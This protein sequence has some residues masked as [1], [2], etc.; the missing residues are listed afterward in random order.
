MPYRLKNR[1]MQIPGGF[2]FLQPETGWQP[3]RFSSFQTIVQAIIS[4]RSANPH[5]A[6]KHNWRMDVAGVE[7]E[8]DTFNATVCAR[9]GWTNYITVPEG[10]PPPPKLKAPSPEEQSQIAAA[11]GRVKKIWSG[12]RT[13]SDWVSQGGEAVTPNRSESRAAVCAACPLNGK[14]D[15]TQ[16]FTAPAAAAIAGMVEKL[17]SRKLSTTHDESLNICTACLCPMKLKVH[18]PISFIKQHLSESVISDL[19]KAPACWIIEE[20]K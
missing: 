14:G 16:W 18:T 10:E 12:V 20:L 5:L 8:L 3:S 15:F 17:K 6:Q 2:K 11:A 19:R 9:M 7:D 4:H 13:L 1:Q